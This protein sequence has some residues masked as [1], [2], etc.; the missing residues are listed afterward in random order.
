MHEAVGEKKLKSFAS[1][2]LLLLCSMRNPN[3]SARHQTSCDVDFTKTR[4]QNANN[5]NDVNN[6]ENE[7][8]FRSSTFSNKIIS[9]QCYHQ[10]LHSN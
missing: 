1:R 2:S 7:I 4:L 5:A 8:E 3:M 9:F 10:E 6:S